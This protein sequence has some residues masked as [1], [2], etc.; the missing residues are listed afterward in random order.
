MTRLLDCLGR[1]DLGVELSGR[2]HGALRDAGKGV[3]VAL[4]GGQKRLDAAVGAAGCGRG[5]QR[6]HDAAGAGR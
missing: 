5:L 3:G 6:A 2:L 1:R 4:A